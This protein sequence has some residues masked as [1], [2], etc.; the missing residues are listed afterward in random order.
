MEE[1][2]IVVVAVHIVVVVCRYVCVLLSLAVYSSCSAGTSI[3]PLRCIILS[4]R[5]ISLSAFDMSSLLTFSSSASCVI[6]MCSTFLPA[7]Y[8]ERCFMNVAMRSVSVVGFG[9]HGCLSSC[10]VRRQMRLR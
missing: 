8:M 4:V 1:R 2:I 6:F 5:F 7:G 3:I 9:C 10:W